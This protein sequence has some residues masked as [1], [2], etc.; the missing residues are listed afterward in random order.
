MTLPIHRMSRLLSLFAPR[1]LPKFGR[2][3]VMVETVK[4]VTT[5]SSKPKASRRRS[6]EAFRYRSR[7]GSGASDIMEEDAL[8]G[9]CGA[10]GTCLVD[11]STAPLYFCGKAFEVGPCEHVWHARPCSSNVLLFCTGWI[12]CVTV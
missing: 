11:I 8:D 3:R 10:V 4:I 6:H 9:G 1:G 12:R 7:V 2:C 5:S